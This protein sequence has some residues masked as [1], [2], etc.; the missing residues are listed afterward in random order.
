MLDML[1]W[2]PENVSTFGEGIDEAF[3]FIYWVSVGIFFL[4]NIIYI[5]FII[6]YRRR[7]R[8]E[9]AYYTHG[10][11]LLE[12]A[13][14]ALPFVLFAGIGIYSDQIW[15]DIKYAE[16]QPNPDVTVEVMGQQYMWHFRYAGSDGVFG[17][18]EMKF[19]SSTNPFGIDPSDPNGKDDVTLI[20]QMNVPINKHIQVKLSSMDVIHSYFLPNMRIK[21]DAVPGTWVDVWFNVD[22]TG[23]YEIACAELCGDGHYLMR[24]ELNAQSQE[25]YDTWINQQYEMKLA[26]LADPNADT[27]EGTQQDTTQTASNDVA[28]GE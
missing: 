9:R 19:I 5:T 1:T 21:Q 28:G 4:I 22:K 7:K 26:S 8:S 3:A 11:N 20:N 17:H 13:W 2:L 12:F 18:R 27:A 14:T 25:E 16:L 10:N 23:T 15:R 24:A 6:K